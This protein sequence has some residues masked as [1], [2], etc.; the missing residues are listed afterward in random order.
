[1]RTLHTFTGVGAG[2][3]RNRRDWILTKVW[4]FSMDAVAAGLLIG[5]RQLLHVVAAAP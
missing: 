3:A 5:L 4:A 1:M 2:D